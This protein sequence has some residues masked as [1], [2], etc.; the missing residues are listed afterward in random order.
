MQFS[1]LTLAGFTCIIHLLFSI[2]LSSKIV[3]FKK[4]KINLLDNVDPENGK[5][6]TT[7]PVKE[8]LTTFSEKPKVK[9]QS[10]KR[11]KFSCFFILLIIIFSFA[12]LVL[13]SDNNSFLA[14][15]KNSYLV[16]QI[17]HILAPDQKYLAGEEN[18]RINF[19][20]L[21][22]GGPGHDGPYLTDTIIIASFKPSTK[23]A[24]LFSLPRDMIVPIKPGD[25]RKINS[26]Y[27]I[28]EKEYEGGGGVLMKKVVS[29]TLDIPIHYYAAVDFNGFVELVDAIG[30]IEID[31]ERSFVDYQFPTY[32]D[33]YQTVSFKDGEQT[34]DGI[35]A[36]RF[37]RSRHGNNGEG[38]DFARIK[39][40]QKILLAA[41]DKVT[42]FNTLINPKKI[43][44]LFS[45]ANEYTKT[46]VEP[47]EAVKL[48][49]LGKGMNTQQIITQS[50]DDGPGGYLRAGY[51]QIDGAYILQ[52]VSGNFQQIQLL[53][54]NIF[55]LGEAFDEEAKI[56]IQNGTSIPGLALN[57]VNYLTQM[58]Y[59]VIRYGNSPNQDKNTTLIYDYTG[60][61]E[62]TK[63]SLEA[64]FQTKVESSVPLEYSSNI[65]AQNW[66]IK[67]ENGELEQLDFLIV[68]GADQKIEDGLEIIA[69]IPPLTNASSSTS[70]E[71]E[72]EN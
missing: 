51:S 34:M 26:V 41:K 8:K 42:S 52:P 33:K 3:D 58:G 31:V 43:T 36:L 48:V 19:L 60:E 53:V 64:I 5:P 25:Y 46:D 15:I 13:S 35:T 4:R 38:S 22:M 55:S 30:G 9:K 16:R 21:G 17:T 29:E 57:A 12:S 27:T 62:S 37:A 66:G 45:I 24:A 40:Q 2:K 11:K 65:I 7:A 6:D 14:G 47:W 72:L 67:D 69:T 32:D 23:Q 70:T 28:G 59:N 49:H 39:R 63:D 18:D 50:I 54:K 20:L 56:V 44:D 68:L 61:K 10:R 71:E 1:P